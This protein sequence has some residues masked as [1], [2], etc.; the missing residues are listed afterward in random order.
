MPISFSFG[1]SLASVNSGVGSDYVPPVGGGAEIEVNFVGQGAPYTYHVASAPAGTVGEGAGIEPGIAYSNF[2]ITVSDLPFNTLVSFTVTAWNSGDT[3]PETWGMWTSPETAP[4]LTIGTP[5]ETTI[6]FTISGTAPAS[7]ETGS[8][9]EVE[10]SDDNTTWNVVHPQ[11]F[12]PWDAV[13]LTGE[14][15]GLSEATPYWTRARAINVQPDPV[16]DP[17]Y[18][19]DCATQNPNTAADETLPELFSASVDADQLTLVFTEAVEF[20]AGGSGGF[21]VDI[22][23][24]TQNIAATTPVGTGTDTIVLTLASPVANGDVVTVQYTNPTNGWQDLATTPNQLASFSGASVT[25]ETVAALD[26]DIVA[27]WRLN[28]NVNDDNGNALPLTLVGSTSWGANYLD[29]TAGGSAQRA[30]LIQGTGQNAFTMTGWIYRTGAAGGYL[31][32]NGAWATFGFV[33]YIDGG[34]NVPTFVTG[35]TVRTGAALVIPLNTWT[36]FALTRASGTGVAL[37]FYVNGALH[38]SWT[39]PDFGSPAPNPLT[40]AQPDG[41]IDDFRIYNTPKDLAFIS[42]LYTAGRK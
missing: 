42:S 7:E 14:F 28:G 22:D 41:Y 3:T 40:L 13:A 30:G 31:L 11:I 15:D 10:I 25:N 16:N 35:T 34:T 2:P 18:S 29:V 37:N 26:P 1:F 6:P 23:G 24:G 5:T 36:H 19:P 32:A 17:S 9:W 12:I 33:L 20:G 4:T 27:Q 21:A 38:A 39:I 8:G